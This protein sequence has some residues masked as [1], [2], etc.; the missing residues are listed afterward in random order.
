MID[1]KSQGNEHAMGDVQWK[2][3]MWDLI[4]NVS[5]VIVATH[6]HAQPR[7]QLPSANGRL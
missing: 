3:K 6:W 7:F 5:Y 4:D 2:W 1:K